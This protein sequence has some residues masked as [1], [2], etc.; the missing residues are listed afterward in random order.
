MQIGA[1]ETQARCVSQPGLR[2]GTALRTRGRQARRPGRRPP[3][4][5]PRTPRRARGPRALRTWGYAPAGLWSRVPQPGAV[6]PRCVCVSK[7]LY[8]IHMLMHRRRPRGRR[9]CQSFP[10]E[11][12]LTPRRRREAHRSAPA[13]TRARGHFVAAREAILNTKITPKNTNVQKTRLKET[14]KR[15]L[16]HGVSTKTGK[17]AWSYSPP[18]GNKSAG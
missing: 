7:P 17:L 16:V 9:R 10:N 8:L 11:A 12:S 2:H 5:P 6:R 18:A 14:L 13:L 3:P 15:T 4:G 1:H